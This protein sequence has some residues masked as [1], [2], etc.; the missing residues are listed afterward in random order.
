MNVAVV[1]EVTHSST[2]TVQNLFSFYSQSC[3]P[4]NKHGRVSHLYTIQKYK[5]VMNDKLEI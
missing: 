3:F 5:E 4:E 1:V 2:V